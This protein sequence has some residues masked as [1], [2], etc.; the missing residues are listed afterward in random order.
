MGNINEKAKKVEEQFERQISE[1]NTLYRN[2]RKARNTVVSNGSK[3]IDIMR[4]TGVNQS[5]NKKE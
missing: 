2:D 5:E 4:M 3:D 1:Q